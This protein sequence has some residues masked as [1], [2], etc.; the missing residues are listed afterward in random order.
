MKPVIVQ[1]SIDQVIN[2]S[3]SFS[4]VGTK[5]DCINCLT[6]IRSC[7]YKVNKVLFMYM[8]NLIIYSLLSLSQHCYNNVIFNFRY[9][10]ALYYTTLLYKLLFIGV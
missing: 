5:H 4:V 7:L 3:A 8:Y 2:F 1:N 6:K 9:S 10:I